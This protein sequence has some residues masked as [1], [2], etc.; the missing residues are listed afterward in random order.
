MTSYITDKLND[1]LL[2][3]T[4]NFLKTN[5]LSYDLGEIT[6]NVYKRIYSSDIFM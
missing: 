3:D 2:N 4:D 6:Q 5:Y 1:N